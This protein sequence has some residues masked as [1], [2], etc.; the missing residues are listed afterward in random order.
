M[1][2]KCKALPRGRLAAAVVAGLGYGRGMTF[3]PAFAS[4]TSVLAILL[5]ACGP[6][7]ASPDEVVDALQKTGVKVEK[8]GSYTNEAPAEMNMKMKFDGEE[9]FTAF[10]FASVDQARDYCQ[11]KKPNCSLEYGYWCITAFES[12]ISTPAWT[13]AKSL[14]KKK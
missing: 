4:A 2:M 10:R 12:Q 8:D 9:G 14:A 7:K 5:V 3:K 1:L 6:Q 11:T 13:K